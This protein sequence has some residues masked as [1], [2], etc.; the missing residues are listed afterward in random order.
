M[1]V[2]TVPIQIAIALLVFSVLGTLGGI[3]I[4]IVVLRQVDLRRLTGLITSQ[5]EAPAPEDDDFFGL[6][7]T[8]NVA[9]GLLQLIA[10]RTEC[11]FAILF[12]PKHGDDCMSAVTIE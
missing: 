5:P 8:G 11:R 4:T 2:S 6:P 9:R 12:L 3:W 7:G 10:A 1:P